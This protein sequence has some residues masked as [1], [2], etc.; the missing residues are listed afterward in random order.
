MKSP[1]ARRA[2]AE[3]IKSWRRRNPEKVAAYNTRYWERKAAQ[4][5]A[6]KNKPKGGKP[7]NE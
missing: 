7:D 1:E 6:E 2:Q 3:Y 4:I 5:E